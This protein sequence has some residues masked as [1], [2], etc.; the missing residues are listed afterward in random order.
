[1][2]NTNLETQ[3][4]ETAAK[5]I[6]HAGNARALANKAIDTLESGS[7]NDPKIDEYLEK[8]DT[9]IEA[10][11]NTQTTVIQREARGEP[12]QFSMLMTHAQDSLMTAMSELH[13]TRRFIKVIRALVANTK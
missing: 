12:I 9:E 6:I 4:V 8:A 7:I 3:L 5:V 1:M 11:H 2:E 13:M 10:A